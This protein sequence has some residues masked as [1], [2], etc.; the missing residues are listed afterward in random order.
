MNN[1]TGKCDVILF[2][3]KVYTMNEADTV[4]EAIGVKDGRIAYVGSSQDAL[5]FCGANSIKINLEGKTV[6]PGF[7]D[8]H[9]HVGQMAVA[10]YGVDL[11]PWTGVKNIR[12]MQVKMREQIQNRR[13]AWMMAS[14]FD[15][16]TIEDKRLMT[17][18]D[19][20]QVSRDIPI[21]VVHISGHMGFIN[22]KAME[23]IGLNENTQDPDGG[24]YR[25][26]YNGKPDGVLLG[27]AL[28]KLTE[29]YPPITGTPTTE[30]LTA[31]IKKTCQKYIE[32]G[33][34]S[35]SDIIM[36]PWI[37]RA[38]QA[39]WKKN[40]L[41][42]RITGYAREYSFRDFERTGIMSGFGDEW[43]KI[44]GIKFFV[45]G[46]M[47]SG[48]AA[49]TNCPGYTNPVCKKPD[50]VYQIF[51]AIHDA[52]FQAAAHC[53]GDYAIK[54]Y[55][56]A[57][58]KILS[59]SPKQ[60]HRHR[61]EHCS[62]LNQ[63]LIIRIKELGALPSLFS[64]MSWF[65][66]DKVKCNLSR[67]AERYSF[68]FRSLLDEGIPVSAHSDYPTT[69]FGP[70]LGISSQVNRLTRIKNEPI[71]PEQQISVYEALKTWTINAAFATFDEK[72]K[73]SIEPGKLADFAVLDQDP[74]NVP[75]ERLGEINV[76]MTIIN[77]KIC[78]ERK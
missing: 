55:L 3:A 72:I 65:H 7:I 51:K 33:M 76:D 12:E 61:I 43:L 74:L 37:F 78:F 49:V 62:I 70:I 13:T 38:Y 17:A 46:G 58:E 71:G 34:T 66:G 77:G 52:G 15:E 40:E 5:E 23:I 45:D 42:L 14:C 24:Q 21:L 19:L 18:E 63:A 32:A 50:E 9:I 53:N 56:D 59:E 69:P 1:L 27:E 67:E 75:S 73:G 2:N 20:D 44:G 68:P 10:E 36:Y 60:D 64:H 26:A 39:L 25:R 6:I 29:Q 8:P 48:T 22:S 31:G 41:P 16:K 30:E 4:A 11:G 47:S 28:W 54:L 35:V 57:L